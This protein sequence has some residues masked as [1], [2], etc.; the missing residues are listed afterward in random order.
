[1][2][3]FDHE[4]KLVKALKYS[5]GPQ[6]TVTALDFFVDETDTPTI[7][8]GF[9]G[10][11]IA[12]FELKTFT[13]LKAVTAVQT[14]KITSIKV[15]KADPLLF[16]ASDE[17]GQVVRYQ[18]QKMLWF[19][20]E[21]HRILVANEA[22]TFD[23]QGLVKELR[24][25]SSESLA[26]EQ[27]L[28]YI[29]ALAKFEKIVIIDA[30]D[31]VSTEAAKV[32]YSF[33]KPAYITESH[34]PSVSWGNAS[35]HQFTRKTFLAIGWGS[36]VHLIKFAFPNA[37][38]DFEYVGHFVMNWTI[39]RTVTWVNESTLAVMDQDDVLYFIQSEDFTEGEYKHEGVAPELPDSP[40]R[41]LM[42]EEQ[43][44]YTYLLADKL[45]AKLS[46][47]DNKKNQK[48]FW[49]SA[50][51]TSYKTHE[52]VILG[53]KGVYKVRPMNALEYLEKLC[54]DNE[55]LKFLTVGLQVYHMNIKEFRVPTDKRKR[56]EV[57]VPFFRE[58]VQAYLENQFK[59]EGESQEFYKEF[60]LSLIDFFTEIEDTEFLF[61]VCQRKM[62]E[63]NLQEIFLEMLEPFLIND[64][65]KYIP[66]GQ[67]KSVIIFYC[68]KGKR[69]LMQKLLL[70]LDLEKQDCFVLLHLCL[71][72]NFYKALVDICTKVDDNYITPFVKLTSDYQFAKGQGREEDARN[73]G[74]RC[75]W[76]LK[77]CINKKLVS[78]SDSAEKQHE[79]WKNIIF[80]LMVMIF[81]PKNLQ[82][83][84]E[85]DGE[86]S[87]CLMLLFFVGD[88]AELVEE[89]YGDFFIGQAQ[90]ND[91]NIDDI[92][93]QVYQ[94]LKNGL[95]DWANDL[96]RNK[97]LQNFGFFHG[98]VAQLLRYAFLDRVLC[99]DFVKRFINDPSLITDSILLSWEK[100]RL[101]YEGKSLEEIQQYFD[102][103]VTAQFIHTQRT[104]IILDLLKYCQFTLSETEINNLVDKARDSNLYLLMMGE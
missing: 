27:E 59:K 70:S 33:F 96:E 51:S 32:I 67:L 56:R 63:F 31:S 11:H 98:K 29:F 82:M 30:R 75:L 44:V 58:K 1:V 94:A 50:L 46:F 52:I 36:V 24:A 101:E 83:L 54:L 38:P 66:D 19:W 5:D 86:L 15:L 48:P 25:R 74:Y 79:R 3:I 42:V 102:S 2:L 22:M 55:W 49:G 84:F 85:V 61:I 69:Q 41:K 12:G 89:K 28:R 62:A 14:Q 104:S 21:E 65:I 7:V 57:L 76:Y 4:E 45:R 97:Y 37:K 17:S 71:E 103:K 53:E 80:Q 35:F 39:I 47:V 90:T 23:I 18:V 60:M 92:H 16:I 6:Q 88:L 87:I 95:K 40:E 99:V 26:E 100:S 68:N 13:L 77:L 34:L 81:E 91:A 73:Y 8:V 20:A 10:G 64:R 72:Y 93:F 43:K 9:S 78:K